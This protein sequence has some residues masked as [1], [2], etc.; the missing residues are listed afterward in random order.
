MHRSRF[1]MKAKLSNVLRSSCK[2][3]KQMPSNAAID[4]SFAELSSERLLISDFSKRVC[5]P[6]RFYYSSFFLMA[7]RLMFNSGFLCF[8]RYASRLVD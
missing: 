8:V 6:F 5:E 4:V 7:C 3:L 2:G 1:G